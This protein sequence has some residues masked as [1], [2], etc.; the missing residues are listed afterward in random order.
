MQISKNPWYHLSPECVCIKGQRGHNSP[1]EIKI[2]I[3]HQTSGVKQA[4]YDLAGFRHVCVLQT[5]DS[6][7]LCIKD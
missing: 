6:P 2:I 5:D 7:L 1:G 4:K 3:K